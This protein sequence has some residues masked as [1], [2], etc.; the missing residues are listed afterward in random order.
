MQLISVLV[1]FTVFFVVSTTAVDIKA[2]DF[3]H[4]CPVATPACLKR[5]LQAAIPGFVR[6]V[7]DLGID[8]LDPFKVDRLALT[9]PG[10][11]NV[12]I[13]HGVTTGFGKCKVMSADM[14]NNNV[15]VKVRCNVV[16]TGK[17][18]SSG[19]LLIF[20][21]DGEGDALIKCSARV[22]Q[23][24]NSN[25]RMIAEE[26]GDPVVQFGV[27]SI[28]SNV[29]RLLSRVPRE[30]LVSTPAHL[31]SPSGVTSAAAAR[32]ALR[33]PA[34]ATRSAAR[35]QPARRPPLR[36]PRRLPTT[37]LRLTTQLLQNLKLK[38]IVR[39]RHRPTTPPITHN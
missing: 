29:R 37:T 21:I 32:T 36:H 25:W 26:F 28:M 9:L 15:E 34:R 20:P 7:P 8:P 39:G 14:R 6:G 2:P 11:I 16:V 30:M 31:T 38:P 5:T 23:F 3:I 35:D 17:Y 18:Q 24:M 1:L 33:T 10:G 19:R 4:P 22:V 12:T 13:L 27:D